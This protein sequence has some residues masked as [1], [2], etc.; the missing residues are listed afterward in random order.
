MLPAFSNK[1][2]QY[3]LRNIPPDIIYNSSQYPPSHLAPAQKWNNSFSW[4][5][6]QK[7]GLSGHSMSA[8]L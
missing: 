6:H 5:S 3:K 4:T 2:K 8:A 7:A 1:N